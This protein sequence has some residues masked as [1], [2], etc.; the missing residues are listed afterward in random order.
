MSYQNAHCG[1]HRK[2]SLG[3]MEQHGESADEPKRTFKFIEDVGLNVWCENC[4]NS[5]AKK[6]KKKKE[7]YRMFNADG[8][9]DRGVRAS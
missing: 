6:K 1:G 8:Y 3:P 9:L 7:V 2:T 4:R 5:N